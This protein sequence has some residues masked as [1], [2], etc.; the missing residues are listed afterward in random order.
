MLHLDFVFLEVQ[1]CGTDS[2]PR[3][4]G[5]LG[6]LVQSLSLIL[7]LSHSLWPRE[8]WTEPVPVA[9]GRE[10]AFPDELDPASSEGTSRHM[11]K[12]VTLE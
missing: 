10:F 9:R 5:L 8:L 2:L 12:E 1:L 11:A 7:S 3:M 4:K 6:N